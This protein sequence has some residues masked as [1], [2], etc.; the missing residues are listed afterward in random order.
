[1]EYLSDPALHV[2]LITTISVMATWYLRGLLS[3]S[4]SRLESRFD[5]RFFRYLRGLF[6][7]DRERSDEQG[8]KPSRRDAKGDEDEDLKS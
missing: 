2:V 1:M 4:S 7:N 6:S 8:R 3:D 5:R